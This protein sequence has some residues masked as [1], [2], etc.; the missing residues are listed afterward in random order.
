MIRME[1]S[2]GSELVLTRSLLY[3]VNGEPRR[4]KVRLPASILSNKPATV[5]NKQVWFTN[6]VTMKLK[7]I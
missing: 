1:N 3:D 2:G 4:E 5:P 6:C 7:R